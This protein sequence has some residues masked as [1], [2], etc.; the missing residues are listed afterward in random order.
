MSLFLQFKERR[1]VE[2]QYGDMKQN[3]EEAQRC[4]S[5]KVPLCEKG[6]PVNTEIRDI[7]K[8]YKDNKMLSAGDKLFKNNP[9]SI[10]CSLVCPHE[11][12]CEGSCV[13]A[14]RGTGVKFGAIENEISKKYIESLDFRIHR[15]ENKRSKVAI[16]GGGPAGIT[17]AFVLTFKGYDVTIFEI[18]PKIGGVM[19]Y[20]IPEFRLSNKIIDKL[21]EKLIE[22][23]VKIRPNVIIGPTLT[24]DNLISDGYSAV[25]IGTG[26]WNPRKLGIKGESLGNVH[27]AID[28]LRSPD[29]FHIGKKVYIIGAGNV[30]VDVGRTMLRKGIESVTLVNREGDE[31]ITANKKEFDEGQYEGMK[32]LNYKTPLEITD[33]GIILAPTKIIEN[34]DGELT[35]T[36]NEKEKEFHEVDTII[37][38]VSQGPRSNIVSRDKEIKVDDRGL[39]VTRADGSTTKDGVFS[40]GD[41]VTGARTVV[42]AV[43]GAKNI[44][45]KMDEYLIIKEKE[46]IEKNKIIENNNL[47]ENDVE[48]IKSGI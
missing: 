30:A 9:L 43:K 5:C 35:Y 45:E 16:I 11:K 40:G 4:I 26:T 18:N 12:Q 1:I 13:L 10:V 34:E 33:D 42:E 14:K 6:C 3:L 32:I 19:R 27:F 41:V 22:I 47:E 24:V 29:N 36:Y 38:A 25:F 44:A 23:G 20:G 39:I 2:R 15:T 46:E 31:G 21:E 48:N 8:L 7:I 17:I 37:I 28:Y